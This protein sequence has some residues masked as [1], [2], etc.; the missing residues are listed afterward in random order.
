M[1]YLNLAA[2]SQ[3]TWGEERSAGVARTARRGSNTARG[4]TLGAGI[5]S[6]GQGGQGEARGQGLL[7][8]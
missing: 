7:A 1:Q 6:S 5:V 4:K 8:H 2:A 3:L